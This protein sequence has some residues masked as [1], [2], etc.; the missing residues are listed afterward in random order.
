MIE[1][2]PKVIQEYAERLH[3]QARDAVPMLFFIGLLSG[4]IIFSGITAWCKIGF[5]ALIVSIGA[6]VGGVMGYSA[7][8]QK[9]FALKLQ[10]HLALCQLKMEES[11]RKR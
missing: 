1:Y 6:L 2:N 7:G 8:Q 9:A 5:D 11:V 10:A 4:M 3:L